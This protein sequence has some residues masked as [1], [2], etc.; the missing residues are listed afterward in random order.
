MSDIVNYEQKDAVVV[1][2]LNRPEAMNAFTT[3]L[4]NDLQLAL[5]R[6]AGDESVRVIV[7][8]G[9]GRCFSAGADLK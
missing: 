2:T 6:A 4:S 3:Q 9:E 5:E 7:L 8:T 1:I